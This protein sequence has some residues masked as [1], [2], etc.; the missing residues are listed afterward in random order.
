MELIGNPLDR[1]NPIGGNK[2]SQNKPLA[3]EILNQYPTLRKSSELEIPI[4]LHVLEN[5]ARKAL[6]D[7]TEREITNDRIRAVEIE[8]FGIQI[9][10]DHIHSPEYIQ[11]L[12]EE[13]RMNKYSNYQQTYCFYTDGSFGKAKDQTLRMGAAWLQEKGPNPGR[14]FQAGV[15]NWP[16]A[17]RAELVAII[18]TLL[19]I[20]QKSQIEI[21]TDNSTCINT[22]QTLQNPQIKDTGKRN[23]KRKN[24]QLW[25]R[26][27]DLIQKKQITVQMTKVKAHSKDTSNNKV[28][29]LA[30]EAK[31][32]PEIIWTKWYRQEALT[33]FCWNE[34]P[35]DIGIREFVKELH[36][37]S[38]LMKWVGQNRIQK[39]WLREIN[40]HE[41]FDW[42]G[43][44]EANRVGGAL[45]TSI[46][47]TKEKSFRIKIMHNELPTLDNM[48]RRFPKEYRNLVNCIY[49]KEEKES[50]EHLFSCPNILE[51]R[52]EIWNKTQDLVLNK[53][54][55]K[56]QEK[57]DQGSRIHIRMLL[58][59]WYI[60]KFS[61]GKDIIDFSLGLFQKE[62]I[63]EWISVMAKL[64]IKNGE[65]K[66]LL[67][68]LSRWVCKQVRKKIW[69]DRC[70]RLQDS[71][72]KPE[73]KKYRRS[74]HM[75]T[76]K[77]K[78]AGPEEQEE[79]ER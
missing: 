12:V 57:K 48:N 72:E 25:M 31:E 36:K 46:K 51:I 28:D 70:S 67:R 54:S 13:Y 30:K 2:R 37:R 18:L 74:N 40:D 66:F 44:W 76:E 4:S 19:V 45:D 65:A 62:D 22:L 63:M 38:T 15:D 10:K 32:E 34:I 73:T 3:I 16:S 29:L 77:K 75:K 60:S 64:K 69:N 6:E 26:C 78:K 50:L 61:Q 20:P 1:I 52:K 59:K 55:S 71:G 17:L 53:W 42:R 11:A 27:I 23:R 39:R 8:D 56:T 24:W 14:S 41:N 47:K 7:F 9:I 5:Q 33:M 35:I 68:K 58:A 21:R 49:C 79:H 43:F